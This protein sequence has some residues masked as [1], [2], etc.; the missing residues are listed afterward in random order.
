LISRAAL[1]AGFSPRP[2]V[3]Q[4]FDADGLMQFDAKAE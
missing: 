3:F 1:A 2:R 4:V